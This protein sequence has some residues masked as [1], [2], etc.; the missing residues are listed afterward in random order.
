VRGLPAAAVLLATTVAR[1]Q[2]TAE[3]RLQ[4]DAVEP[5]PGEALLREEL[6]RRLGRDPFAASADALVRVTIERTSDKLVAT[7][8]LQGSGADWTRTY[9]VKGTS[10]H[11]CELVIE[12][13][14]VELA[15]ELP[16]LPAAAPAPAPASPSPAPVPAPASSSPAPVPAP[17]SPGPAPAKVPAPERPF[18]LRVG[19]AGWVDLGVVPHPVFGLRVEAGARVGIFSVA[20]ELHWIP[21]SDANLPSNYE[22]NTTLLAG[23]LVGCVHVDRHASFAGCAVIEVGQTQRL[24]VGQYVLPAPHYSLYAGAGVRARMEVPI[25]AHF[26]F[27]ANAQ[28][29]AGQV[30]ENGGTAPVA[31]RQLPDSRVQFGPTGGL[32]AGFGFSY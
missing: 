6:R 3:A 19:A 2:G 29:L 10:R 8:Q 27:H 30:P 1:A 9:A 13:V 4:Y 25:G 32:G 5:C 7:Y 14:A 28:V 17:A 16:A 11:A 22:L 26:Y 15:V 21:S 23:A 20:G 31:Q 24:L 18:A 12:G